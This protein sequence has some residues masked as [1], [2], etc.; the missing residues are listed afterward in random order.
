M[1]STTCDSVSLK[2]Q[3][4]IMSTVSEGVQVKECSLEEGLNVRH[5]GT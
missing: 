1:A 2:T 4:L 5:E 3:I